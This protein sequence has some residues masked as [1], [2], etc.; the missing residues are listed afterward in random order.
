[1]FGGTVPWGCVRPTTTTR[2]GFGQTLRQLEADTAGAAGNDDLLAGLGAPRGSGLGTFKTND[3]ASL[4][5]VHQVDRAI[6]GPQLVD[7][8]IG[9]RDSLCHRDVANDTSGPFARH[10]AHETGNAGRPDVIGCMQVQQI[11]SR[12]L[13]R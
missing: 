11:E 5:P 7:E 12:C 8:R 9:R 2:A 4:G 3:R 1:M 13:P 6:V 10:A